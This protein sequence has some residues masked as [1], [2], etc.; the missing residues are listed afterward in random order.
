MLVNEIKLLWTKHLVLFFRDQ[1]LTFDQHT[2][3]GR[4]FGELH[5]HPAAPKDADY[6]E[7]LVV[8]GDNKVKFRRWRTLALRRVL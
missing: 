7:I 2:D 6:P 8:H 3:L 1:N 4:R 5:I